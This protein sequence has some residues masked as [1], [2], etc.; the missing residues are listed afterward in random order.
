MPKDK[1]RRPLTG[2][3][4]PISELCQMTREVA[5][6]RGATGRTINSSHISLHSPF[7]NQFWDFLLHDNEITCNSND[8]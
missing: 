6:S 2:A 4:S 3:N 8:I 5:G 7:C 1:R